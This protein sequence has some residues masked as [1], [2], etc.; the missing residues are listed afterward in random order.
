MRSR[1]DFF[2]HAFFKKEKKLRKEK[3]QKKKKI[4]AFSGGKKGYSVDTFYTKS[5][6]SVKTLAM[7]RIV[8]DQAE[9]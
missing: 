2:S 8:Q 7:K 5:I 3:V 9:H 4:A 6:V 1:Q